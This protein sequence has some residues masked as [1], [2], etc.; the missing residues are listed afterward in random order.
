MDLPG[1]T[2]VM[3]PRPLCLK[4]VF[5]PFLLHLGFWAGLYRVEAP[6]TKLT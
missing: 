2:R 5:P 4:D 1:G 6:L 3:D